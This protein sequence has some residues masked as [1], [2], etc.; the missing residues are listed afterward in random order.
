[1]QAGKGPFLNSERIQVVTSAVDMLEQGA[2]AE[3]ALEAQ[4][5]FQ[6]LEFSSIGRLEAVPTAVEIV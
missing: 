4:D 6:G 3:A 5:M 1:M 2:G